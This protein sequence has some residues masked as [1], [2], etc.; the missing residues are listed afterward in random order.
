[1]SKMTMV[2]SINKEL[3]KINDQI[4]RK[5]VKGESYDREARRHREL[6]SQLRQVERDAAF[7]RSYSLMSF[8]L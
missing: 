6:R 7:N 3:R 5:I 2:F 1:M 4:D 8:F